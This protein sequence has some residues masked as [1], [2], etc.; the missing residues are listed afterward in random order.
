M[1]IITNTATNTDVTTA[2]PANTKIPII[3]CVMTYLSAL[4]P[5]GHQL[6]FGLSRSGQEMALGIE[7][8]SLGTEGFGRQ[9]AATRL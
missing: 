4:D 9:I 1:V 7:R 2:I 8:F 6:I 5:S 3:V